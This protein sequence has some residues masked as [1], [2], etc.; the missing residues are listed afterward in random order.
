MYG[1]DFANQQAR[2]VEYYDLTDGS[3][4]DGSDL[5]D[6]FSIFEAGGRG[7]GDRDLPSR[8]SARG[9]AAG[10]ARSR[11]TP[12]RPQRIC[13]FVLRFLL[14]VAV[15]LPVAVTCWSVSEIGELR[16]DRMRL[17]DTLMCCR[18]L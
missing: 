17:T 14:R 15:V 5:E 3:A 6:E 18:R 4:T 13:H 9:S 12:S 10:A 11:V 1:G 16:E 2:R 8:S 7:P